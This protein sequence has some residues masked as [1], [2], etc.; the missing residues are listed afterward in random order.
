LG[1]APVVRP[2]YDV[3]P[4]PVHMQRRCGRSGG[5]PSIDRP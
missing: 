1:W 3:G 2:G 5:D 4:G